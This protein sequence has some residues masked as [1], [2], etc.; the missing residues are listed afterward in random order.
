MALRAGAQERERMDELEREAALC[1]Q[2]SSVQM[3][4]KSSVQA[5]RASATSGLQR[6]V[7]R[8]IFARRSGLRAITTHIEASNPLSLSEYMSLRISAVRPRSRARRAT[9]GARLMW[10]FE[11]WN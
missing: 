2:R 5:G 7:S 3:F 11:M 8:A 1:Y 10:R 9:T 4:E 6:V